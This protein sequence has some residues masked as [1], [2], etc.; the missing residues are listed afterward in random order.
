MST[1]HILTLWDSDNIAVVLRRIESGEAPAPSGVVAK[2]TVPSG[3][4]IALKPIG[5]GREVIKY[6][7]V[8]GVA[9]HDIQAGEHLHVHNSTC[10]VF[11]FV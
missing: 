10:S 1:P 11:P 2:E 4:K 6:G 7:R 9:T 8:I 3:H 5:A